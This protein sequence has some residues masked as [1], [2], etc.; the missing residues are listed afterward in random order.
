MSCIGNDVV[1]WEHPANSNKSRDFR[2]LKKILTSVEIE[3]VYDSENPDKVLWSL[4]ACKETAYKAIRKSYPGL[5][6]L[7]RQWSVR[8]NGYD[9]MFTEGEVIIPGVNTVFA[10]LFYLP[11]GCVHCVGADNRADLDNIIWGIEPLPEFTSGEIIEPSSFVRKCLVRK[12]AGLYQL[13]FRELE[14]R[15]AKEGGELQPPQLYYENRETSFDISLSHDGKF[16]AYAFLK[17][18]Y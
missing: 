17:Q 14:V 7:P 9:K 16:A 2:Y 13:N 1:D 18:L 12:L 4:W 5:S 6:F 8:L 3:F 11:E 15:R 10:R